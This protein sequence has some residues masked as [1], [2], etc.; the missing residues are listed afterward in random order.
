MRWRGKSDVFAPISSDKIRAKILDLGYGGSKLWDSK[1][2]TSNT[3][4]A[5]T[6]FHKMS[7]I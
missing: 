6:D 2:K 4:L 3:S 5:Y 7:K 1:C